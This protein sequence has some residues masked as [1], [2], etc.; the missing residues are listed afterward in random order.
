MKILVEPCAGMIGVSSF[1][2]KR[3]CPLGGWPGSKSGYAHL[4]ADILGLSSNEPPAG[5]IWGDVGPNIAA[6]ATVY[7]AQGNA[8]E[9]ARWIHAN[10]LSMVKD[11]NATGYSRVNGEGNDYTDRHGAHG[12]WHATTP[13]VSAK[14]LDAIATL[15][16][17][18]VANFLI[19]SDLSAK[20]EPD[21]GYG[22]E[23]ERFVAGA[24]YAPP[25]IGSI[26]DR[27][28]NASV[29]ADIIRSWQDEEPRKLWQRL[30]EAGWPSLLLP[31]GS[32]GRWLGPQSVEDTAAWLWT[33]RRSWKSDVAHGFLTPDIV[34]GPKSHGG[35]LR[36]GPESPANEVEEIATCTPN[37]AC[38][39]G[40]AQDMPL[41]QCLDDFVIF[42][43]GPYHGDGSRKISGYK[44][45][46]F[47]REEQLAYAADCHRR[48]AHVAVS[49]CVPLDKELSALTGTQWW[50]VDI[51]H[52]RKGSTRSWSVEKQEWVTV[53]KP[54][55]H[56][57][58]K[59]VGLFGQ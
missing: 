32:T 17:Q 27:I 41:P 6:L 57:P 38:W 11:G 39:Q 59:Q 23:Y 9:V 55:V 24:R 56:V 45:G 44:H 13:E 2:L 12:H 25:N 50:K 54:P 26:A 49:E 40:K 15:S 14:R 43:D 31:E 51:G 18:D 42:L 34:K 37:V 22:A 33:T 5:Y 16:A 48:G 10:A 21:S 58:V 4:I 53:N 35:I 1:L 3:K 47:T 7:G 52:A 36:H 29:V 28:P 30:K 46:T 8:E 20:K 19:C